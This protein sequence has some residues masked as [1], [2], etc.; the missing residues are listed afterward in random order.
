MSARL[1]DLYKK[2]LKAGLQKELELKNVMQVP[3]LLKIVI[4]TGV[5]E[6]VQDS[7]VLNGV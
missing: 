7:K 2:E 3:R 1:D 6:A 4:N 5:K